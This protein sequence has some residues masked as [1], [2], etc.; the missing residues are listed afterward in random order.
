MIGILNVLT[1]IV[2]YIVR[3]GVHRKIGHSQECICLFCVYKLTKK[4]L[5][6]CWKCVVLPEKRVTLAWKSVAERERGWRLKVVQLHQRP[7]PDHHHFLVII[8][9][10][11]PTLYIIRQVELRYTS[12]RE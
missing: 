2:L 7:D 5:P 10:H 1:H 11:H 12:I 3:G 8:H 4:R 6:N 9:R